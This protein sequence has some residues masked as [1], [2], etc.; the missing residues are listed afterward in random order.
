MFF[1]L[2]KSIKW[3]LI[4]ILY[5]FSSEKK[6]FFSRRRIEGFIVF[7]NGILLL[8]FYYF[9]NV[10][11]I[12]AEE[13]LIYFIANMGYAGWQTVQ[14]FNEKLKKYNSTN[15]ASNNTGNLDKY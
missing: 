7:V 11:K 10:D 13:A 14:M 8:D 6:S 1:N 5:T 2:F 12:S 3:F 9:S 15:N 4:Q